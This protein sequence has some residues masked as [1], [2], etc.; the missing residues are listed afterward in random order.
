M[1]IS[2]VL[3]KFEERCVPARNETYER[4]VFFKREQSSSESLDNYITALIE[5][6]ETCSFGS[7]GETLVRDRLIFWRER[8]QTTRKGFRPKCD[9]DL[10]K[11]IEILKA[12]DVTHY[13]ATEISHEINVQESINALKFKTDTDN[14]ECHHQRTSRN[15]LIWYI[16]PHNVYASFVAVDTS[17]K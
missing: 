7:L 1:K 10:D 9:L 17:W 13:R 5:L 11:A 2:T 14:P 12:V 15:P 16:Q 3:E 4:Y 6:S 8:R